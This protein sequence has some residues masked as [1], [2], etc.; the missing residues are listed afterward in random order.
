[1]L[2]TRFSTVYLLHGLGGSPAGS[3]LQ[4]QTELASLAKDRTYI[5][6]LLPHADSSVAPS[7]SVENLK[8]LELPEGAL[9]VGISMGG[10][11]AAKLQEIGRQDLH[12]ICISSPVWAVDVELHRRVEHRIAL[13]S[14]MDQV[15]AGRTERW[16]QLADA[17]DLAW[18]NNHD[19]DPHKRR[20]A[21]I[22]CRYMDTG[23]IMFDQENVIGK[24]E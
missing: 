18:L 21:L 17:F 2:R 9:V 4:L 23:A 24:Q 22:L 5:R 6:P 11:V 20:L 12:V 10:L 13:Y 8:A 14:S 15:I 7:I 1:M 3:V 16:P 19:I